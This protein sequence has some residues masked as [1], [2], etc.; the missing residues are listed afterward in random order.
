VERIVLALEP[1]EL[2]AAHPP[3]EDFDGSVDQ[4]HQIGPARVHRPLVD[5]VHL[6]H[7]EQP[8]VALICQGRVHAAIADH[9][10]AGGECGSDDL[11]DVLSAVC[12]DQQGFGAVREMGQ[13]GVVEDAADPS[14]DVGS[15]GFTGQ[16]GIEMSGEPG[17][18]RALPSA[19]GT[20]EGD[21][22]TRTHTR[23]TI[24]SRMG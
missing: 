16:H 12:R 19:L 18:V 22:A 11:V 20:F 1:V 9:M 17:G 5:L 8:S 13:R 23:R 6:V 24:S 4:H 3:L 10:P 7:R 14:P 2:A 15:P 21:V